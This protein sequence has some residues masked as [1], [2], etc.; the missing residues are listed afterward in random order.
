MKAE[1]RKEDG[2]GG[3]VLSV[4]GEGDAREGKSGRGEVGAGG[5]SENREETDSWSRREGGVREEGEGRR[6]GERRERDGTGRR[7]AEGETGSRHCPPH[8]WYAQAKS[9]PSD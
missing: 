5:G 7:R 8:D 3:M 6:E 2:E 4:M 1:G 9:M